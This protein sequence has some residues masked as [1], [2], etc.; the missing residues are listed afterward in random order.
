[1]ESHRFILTPAREGKV[2]SEGQL[3][4]RTNWRD[5]EPTPMRRLRSG[6]SAYVVA[7]RLKKLVSFQRGRAVPFATRTPRS[8]MMRLYF[9]AA[10]L[11]TG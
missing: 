5:G 2:Q 10:A 7:K 9:A 3:T 11:S 1:M 6:K 8:S 4:R